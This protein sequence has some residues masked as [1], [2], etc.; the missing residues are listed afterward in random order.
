MLS[1]TAVNTND[2]RVKPNR[3]I[4]LQVTFQVQYVSLIWIMWMKKAF[5]NQ[6]NFFLKN[7]VPCLQILLQLRF[8]IADP[9][10]PPAIISS[11]TSWPPIVMP[12]YMAEAGANG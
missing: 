2:T 4:L 5:G 12:N 10:S 6:K 11:H 3:L 7:L 9:V 8:F 1:L